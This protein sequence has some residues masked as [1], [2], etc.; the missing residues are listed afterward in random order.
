MAETKPTK[1]ARWG[2]DGGTTVEPASGEKDTGWEIAKKPPARH[3]NW[4]QNIGYQWFNWLNERLF[5]G[6]SA[7]DFEIRGVDIVTGTDVDGGDL[8]LGGGSSTGD[9]GSEVT[10]KVAEADQGAGADIRTPVAV[11]GFREN[12]SFGLEQLASAPANGVGGQFY[13][14]D[15]HGKFHQYQSGV[16]AR[17]PGLVYALTEDSTAVITTGDQAFDKKITIPTNTLKAG[18]V[19][20]V[21]AVVDITAT[22]GVGNVAFH[23]KLNNIEI[24][25]A[26]S[27]AMD[28]ARDV[29]MESMVVVRTPGV[30]AVI[31]GGGVGYRGSSGALAPSIT[32]RTVPTG[33]IDTTGAVEVA[34]YVNLQ[35]AGGN[36]VK[37]THLVVEII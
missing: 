28:L 4:L 24:A 36:S 25:M 20:K 32:L 16:W 26:F 17:I 6:G 37:L 19:I 18:S 35:N 31:T 29:L 10:F 34:V 7:K 22:P 23:I 8:E 13:A 15:V 33:T 2:T 11:G 9:G 12:K 30:D 5:D 21:R 27:E 14:D 3:M 1:V